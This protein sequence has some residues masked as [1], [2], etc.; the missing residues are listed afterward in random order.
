MDH[1]LISDDD[2][3][4]LPEEPEHR[5]LALERICRNNMLRL[6]GHENSSEYDTEIQVHYMAMVAEA[7]IEL[8]IEGLWIPSFENNINQEIR[9]FSISVSRIITHLK[10]R[11]MKNTS[12]YTV[13]LN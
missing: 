4:T 2:Y 3:D 6:I 11:N 1:D 8:G 10:F 5:F 12:T 9:D 13:Q 7:A